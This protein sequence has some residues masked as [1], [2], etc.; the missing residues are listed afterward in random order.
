[1]TDRISIDYS[2][3]I[4]ACEYGGYDLH[5]LEAK[6]PAV[7]QDPPQEKITLTLNQLEK[8]SKET[9]Y[10]FGF[11]FTSLSPQK[12]A[13]PVP[14]LRTVGSVRPIE[15]SYALRT[16]LDLCQSR[17]EWYREYARTA[18]FEKVG[19]VCSCQRSDSPEEIARKYARLLRVKE[20][21]EAVHKKKSS[22]LAF[23]KTLRAALEDHQILTEASGIAGNNTKATLD[24]KEFRGFAITDDYAPLVFVNKKD[25][26]AAQVFTLVHEL[27]HILLGESGVSNTADDA[28]SWCNRF[29]AEVLVPAAELTQV[30]SFDDVERLANHYFVSV[31]VILLR[32][33]KHHLI[34]DTLFNE[35]MEML[36]RMPV[37][38]KV[39][40]GGGDA[41]RNL[42]DRLSRRFASA[43][44]SSAQSGQTLF[45][46]AFWLLGANGTTFW[47]LANSLELR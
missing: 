24:I 15:L 20:I 40:R 10:P 16:Q 34:C 29:A 14:D 43:L 32:L 30:Q 5:V 4:E 33:K 19:L 17:V 3:L 8:I 18:H 28:E 6:I 35:T 23:F 11:F 45:R 25:A 36:K 46:D 31:Q 13:L 9:H 26:P 7:K 44:I 27:G 41:I 39:V 12:P 47:K 22:A 1:M 38:V 2:K 42:S 37:S 21:R